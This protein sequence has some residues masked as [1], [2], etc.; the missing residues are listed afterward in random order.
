MLGNTEKA[1]QAFAQALKVNP[2]F[3][4]AAKGLERARQ[5]AASAHPR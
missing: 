4:P 2:A 5:Q 3:A 1:T